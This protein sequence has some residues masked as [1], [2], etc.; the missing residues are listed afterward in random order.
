MFYQMINKKYFF[1]FFFLGITSSLISQNESWFFLRANNENINPEFERV[2]NQLVYKGKDDKLK[3]LFFS[4]KI[5]EFK[6][7]YQNA[8]KK[9]LRKTFFV[10]AND[11]QLLED[12]LQNFSDKFEFGEI[13]SDEDKKIFEPND[14][15][16]TSTIGEN[17]GL[18]ADLSY[19]D[20]LGL[21]K[22]WYYT[23]GSSKTIIGISDATIDSLNIDF[24]GKTQTIQKSTMSKGHG[25]AVASIAASQGD[26]EYG[27]PGIC[28]DCSIYATQYGNFQ[29]LEQLI[30][31]SN[32]GVK[33]INCSWV[34][35][36]YYQ[37]AQDVIDEMFDNGTIIVAGSGNKGWDIT[38]GKKLYYPA[39]Y[40]HVISVSA[41]MYRYDLVSDNI[42][43]SDKGNLYAENIKGYVGRTVG[44]KN[45]DL[46]NGHYI[47]PVS[48]TTLNKEVDILAPTTGVLLFNKYI[49][50]NKIIY[51]TNEHTSNTTPFVTGTIGLLFSLNP[52]LPIDEVESI[53]KLTTLN[54]DKINANKPYQGNYGA[55]ILQIGAAVKLVY[56]LFTETE[57][58]TIE[59]QNFTRWDFKLTAY[60]K[61]VVIQNQKFT[62][63]SRLSLTAKNRI[64]IG[65][66]TVLKP[67]AIGNI[68]L[69]ID[70]TLEKQCDLVLREGFPNNKYYDPNN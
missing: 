10:V 26:N 56:D 43:I 8:N 41:G 49:L 48:T 34:G 17:L 67:N 6:K 14:Y 23:T 3:R 25:S 40:N 5:Y 62:N 33:V 44:F 70:P 53:I 4:Y 24:K 64:V 55:G 57:V 52:C 20:F 45:N 27:V 65:K 18:Q 36:T 38:K 11:K 51:D 63:E 47:Y 66:N 30:E 21:P 28:Y 50:D 60:S 1:L 39:S 7:T 54:L 32:M 16:F 29:K 22:A 69:K 46:K 68:T 9:N 2:D 35:S 13:I 19:L 42:L 58:A 59:N 31:L 15:G 12:L 37:T 61:E